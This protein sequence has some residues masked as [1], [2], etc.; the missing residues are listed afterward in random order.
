LRIFIEEQ[1]SQRRLCAFYLRRK[2]GL[3]ERTDTGRGMCSAATSTCRLIDLEPGWP[4]RGAQTA[5]LVR[6]PELSILV[7]TLLLV[8][9]KLVGRLD[10]A[11]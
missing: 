10:L 3:F 9:I 11:R 1:V 5:A 8:A 7:N 2:Q 6:S 4:C